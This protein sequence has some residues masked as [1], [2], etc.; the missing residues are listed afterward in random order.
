MED[1]ADAR[2]MH[3]RRVCNNFEIKNLGE[4][5]DLYLKSDTLLLGD[6]SENFRKIC[7]NIYHLDPVKFISAHGLAWQ[8]ALKRSELKLES[9]TDI[10]MLSMLEKGIRAGIC[11]AIYQYVQANNK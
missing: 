8:A 5:Y 4:Y 6:V 2:Y 10:D 7:L 3:A 1:I 11:L 9:L